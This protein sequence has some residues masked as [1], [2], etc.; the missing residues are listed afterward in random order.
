MEKLDLMLKQNDIL[1]GYQVAM[2]SVQS[3]NPTYP[4]CGSVTL[5]RSLYTHY[6]S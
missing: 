4:F 3:T 6:I 5:L 1:F 2:S